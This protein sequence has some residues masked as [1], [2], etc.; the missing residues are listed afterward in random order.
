MFK[1][2]KITPQDVRD[3]HDLVLVTHTGEK[4]FDSKLLN[5]EKWDDFEDEQI[6]SFI[7]AFEKAHTNLIDH[8]NLEVTEQYWTADA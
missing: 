6:L 1:K 3:N 2:E 4:R 7:A 5:G 8:L